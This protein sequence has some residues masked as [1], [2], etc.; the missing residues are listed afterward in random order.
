MFKRISAH[1]WYMLPEP[2]SDRP[3]LGYI[4]GDKYAFAADAG[5]SKAHVDKFYGCLSENGL[6]LPDFTG[7]SHYHWDHSYGLFA[8]SGVSIAS[9][10]TNA[11]LRKEALFGW[12][13]A[14]MLERIS[15]GQDIRFC[16]VTRKVEY[17]DP[18]EIK[19]VPAD[20]EISADT[21]IDLGGVHVELIYCGGP[22]S[23]DSVMFLVPEDRV[24]FVADASGK[25]MFENEWC[26]DESDMSSIDAAIDAIPHIKDRLIPYIDL[27]E[28]LGF[29][30]AVLG[31]SD[32]TCTK[33]ELIS[34]L[35]EYI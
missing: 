5:A 19:I 8:C 33:A 20:M 15:D 6:P 17:P 27:L 9:D 21:S 2:A 23:R 7:V 30:T 3:A 28:R 1:T 25:D 16:Y 11:M 24:L 26:F 34:Y 29:D 32:D 14:E 22:H 18:K 10:R 4:K 12:S 31:H 35:S 13:E